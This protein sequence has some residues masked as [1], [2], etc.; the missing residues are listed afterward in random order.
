MT[1]VFSEIVQWLEKLPFWEQAAFEKIFVG[2]Q[3]AEA[4]YDELVQYL[5][6]DAGLAAPAGQRPELQFKSAT[7]VSEYT[8]GQI[9]LLQI[10]NTQNVNAL[11]PG[12]TL[13]F[14][15]ALTAIFGANASGKSGYA[16][17]LGCAGFTRG[18]KEVLPDITQ[19]FDTPAVLSADITIYDG[20][21]TKM[22]PYE[23]GNPCPELAQFYVFDS[24]SVL[25]HLIGS[26]K[27][28]FS[29]ASL[30]Y[31][32]RLADLTD[33][34]RG[35]LRIKIEEYSQPHNFSMLFPGESAVA[36]LIANLGP[37]TSLEELKQLA[38]L[39]SEEKKHIQKLDK[40]IAQLKTKDKDAQISDLNQSIQDLVNLAKQLHAIEGEL[41]RD[42]IDEIARAVNRYVEKESNAQRLGIDQ[43]K[44]EHFTQ[45]GSE[46][47]YRFV[48]AAKALA[49]AEQ[50][51]EKPYPQ[52]D[53]YCLLCQQHLTVEARNLLLRL[54][55]FL[56][57]EAQA[58]LD[59][60]RSHLAE[61]RQALSELDLDFFNDQLV[62]YRCLQLNDQTL[63]ME[64]ANFIKVCQKRLDLALRLI[65]SHVEETMPQMPS[66]GINRISKLI[67]T[68][69]K[70]REELEKENTSQQIATLQQQL[71]G[72]QHR[73]MLSQKLSEISAYVQRRIWAQQ[74]SKVGSDTGH[75]TR[76]HNELFK[77]LVTERYI[78]L[79]QNTLSDL[80]RPL[81]VKIET[82]GLKGAAYKQI[83][84]EVAPTV[85]DATPDRVLSEGEKRAVA[86]AD[87]LTEVALDTTSSGIVLD[88]PVT[89]LD[90]EWRE[91][92]AYM[93]AEEAKHRQVIVFTHDL[94]F[95]YFL[96]KHAEEIA[97]DVAA[98]WI[99]RGEDDDKPGHVYCNNCPA[100]ERDY[101]TAKQARELYELAKGAPPAEQGRLL[102]DGFGALRTAYE[103]FIIFD[104]FNQVV[105]RF[106]ERVSFSRLKDIKWDQSIADE[107]VAKCEHLSQYIEGHLHSDALGA[108]KLKPETLLSE[109]Q[110]F[111][112]L[113]KKLKELK[114][115]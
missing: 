93:L 9:K 83:A 76:K 60:A 85:A 35:C 47:W 34:V 107:V 44:S 2:V 30:F 26:N 109:I 105:M 78:E 43:F 42:A 3:C 11:V 18:D 22:V 68:L 75:I 8:S 87:F 100:L 69:N 90:L 12:Q 1:N 15:P 73:E 66:S 46:V 92:I 96:K 81:K 74:A 88:D 113:R 23:I 7:A 16:R 55:D 84:L 45:A 114:S 67:S 58:S 108:Q 97:V 31:L 89:S 4:D 14:G 91:T 29:P 17:I 48:E 86:L 37:E 95:L 80:Q 52:P 57:D 25:R 10:S 5:L 21:T 39:T 33:K 112:S 50:S 71:V 49:E 82:M 40:Q 70:Q 63:L 104:L 110:Y 111:D 79:F 65:D 6:E 98:H 51:L 64:V 41:C 72:L 101:R 102:R 27:F 77:Q 115:R 32:T 62:S 24:T 94:L 103:A 20:T 56:K 99:K 28:S 13:T 61:E 19:C 36:N 53:D 54:W 59:E 38:A 106:E